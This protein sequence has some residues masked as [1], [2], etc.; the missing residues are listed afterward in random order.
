MSKCV[1]DRQSDCRL[2]SCPRYWYHISCTLKQNNVKLFPRV[3][4]FN[5]DEREPSIKRICVAPSIEQCIT[6]VP[7]FLGDHFEIYK[8]KHK[9]VAT[10][11]QGV[12]D[13]NI[14]K[15]GWLLKPTEFIKLG[16]INFEEVEKGINVENVISP[17]ASGNH[18]PYSGKVLKWWKKARIKRF[19][20]SA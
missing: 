8:T 5:R 18:A 14:T 20:K 17:A 16:S 7:Y 12:F 13:S 2:F 6:A 11:P 4:G 9:V 3:E 10:K 1:I 19:I 15:E